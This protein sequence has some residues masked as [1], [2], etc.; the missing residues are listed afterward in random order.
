MIGLV[1]RGF[2]ASHHRCPALQ[3]LNARFGKLKPHQA[4]N[5]ATDD[6]CENREDQIKRADILVVGRHEPA[7]EKARLV[8]RIMCVVVEISSGRSDRGHGQSAFFTWLELRQGRGIGVTGVGCRCGQRRSIAAC[9]GLPFGGNSGWQRFVGCRHGAALRF[10]PCRKLG[11]RKCLYSNRHE[12][13]PRTAKLGTL[14]EIHAWLG[15]GQ[16]FFVKAAGNGIELEPQRRHGE[17]VD[18]VGGSCLDT[19]GTP[20]GT[21]MRLSTAS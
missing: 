10:H 7:G 6:P 13:V 15:D 5:R 8:V 12:S 4:R 2:L 11:W 9:C 18:D 1:H 3:I 17:S 16:R 20:A 21:T 14:A 19:D